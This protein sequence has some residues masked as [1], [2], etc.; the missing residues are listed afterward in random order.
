MDAP[1]D[2]E[3]REAMG[4]PV[5]VDLLTELRAVADG[6]PPAIGDDL[7]AVLA[8]VTPLAAARSRRTTARVVV[9]GLVGASVLAG[10]VGAAAAADRLPDPV[11]R[12]VARIVNGVTPFTIANPDDQGPA[13]HPDQTTTDRPGQDQPGQGHNPSV[14]PTTSSGSHNKPGGSAEQE[15]D[16]HT[17]GGASVQDDH[18][19][20]GQQRVGGSDSD[21]S[22]DQRVD[23]GDTDDSSGHS[24]TSDGADTDGQPNPPGGEQGE[25]GSGQD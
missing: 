21:E 18:E 3:L 12:V 25:S 2:T 20:G 4:D 1:A 16:Q 24:G 5:L 8:A 17:G 14:G 13:E 10:G 15:G 23:T 9:I 11:Q 22:S 6:R 19:Q 7:M